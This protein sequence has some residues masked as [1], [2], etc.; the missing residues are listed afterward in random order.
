MADLKPDL[1]RQAVAIIRGFAYQ[2]YQTIRA[3]LQCGPD[4]ELRCEFAEDFDLV[5]RDIAG[6]VMEAEL[7]QVK[8]EKKNVTLNSD[9]VVQLINNFFRH[10][11]I[12]PGLKLKMRLCTISDRSQESRVDWPYATCGMDLWDRL[13]VRELDTKDQRLAIEALRSHLQGNTHLS[14][15]AKNFL[16]N[17]TDSTFLSDFVDAIFWDTG[18]PPYSEIEKE[19]HG[20][21]AV[22]RR[23]ITN[24][25]EV[26]Q[27]VNRLWKAVIDLLASDSDR[28][29]TRA[30]L[31][32]VL[33]KETTVRIDRLLVQEMTAGLGDITQRMDYLVAALT[34]K[35]INSKDAIELRY[36]TILLSDQLPPLHA[37]CSR[38]TQLVDDIR[39][40]SQATS[41]LWICGSTGYG[42]TTIA[43]LI[44]RDV[45]TPFLWFRLRDLVNFE[46]TSAL[47]FILK[48]AN[49]H[50]PC[51]KLLIVLDDLSLG[52]TD[53]RNI[54]LIER[55]VGAAKAKTTEALVIITSQGFSPS[56]L[57]DLVSKQLTAFDMPAMSVDEIRELVTNA[58]LTDQELLPFW[59]TFIQARTHGHPQLV[60]AYI[61]FGKEVG[62]KFSAEDFTNTPQSAESVKSE[63]RRLLAD[64]LHS[65]EARELARRLSVV[66]ISFPR[67]FA[68]AIGRAKPPLKEPGHA[69]DSL[70]GPWIEAIDDKHYSLS[71]L[72]GGYADS[73][74]GPAGLAPFYKMAAYSWFAQKT[75]NQVQF[76]QLVTCALLASEEFLIAHTGY[77]LLTTKEPKFQIM[78]K[79][80]SLICLLG[81]DQTSL[82]DLQPLT[83][84]LFRMGQM[85]I[86]AQIG[87]T[88][89]YMKL[90]AAVLAELEPK[91]DDNIH[92]SFLFSYYLQTS[93]DPNSPVALR[94]R[95]NR[96]IKAVSLFQKR[97][98]DSDYLTSLEVQKSVA[99]VLMLITSK[100]ESMEDLQY[101]VDELGRQSAETITLSLAGFEE[102]PDLL[103]LLADR[104][105]MAETKHQEPRWEQCQMVLSEVLEFAH[106]HNIPWLLAGAARAKMVVFDEYLDKPESALEVANDARQKLGAN[107]PVIDLAESTVRF[108][109]EEYSEC[110]LLFDRADK[111]LPPEH[112]TLERIFALRRVIIAASKDQEWNKIRTCSDRGLELVKSLPDK[113]LAEIATCAFQLEK[114]WASHESGERLSAIE[115]FESA[116]KLAER[117][118]DQRQPLFHLLR[119]RFGHTL[120]WLAYASG[121][122]SLG[123]VDQNASSSRPFSGMFANFDEPPS[124][125][126]DRNGAPYEGLWAMLA[127]YAA[128]YASNTKVKS[129]TDRAVTPT[130]EGQCYLALWS[131][132][133]ALFANQLAEEDFEA[134]LLTGL[135]YVKIETVGSAYSAAGKDAI[136]QGYG[137]FSNEE[138]SLEFQ[139]QWV[140]AIPFRVFEPILM[141]LCSVDN[142]PQINFKAWREVL[143]NRLGTH[144]LIGTTL[145]CL[146]IGL[147][148]AARDAEATKTAHNLARNSPPVIPALQRLGQLI[149]CASKTL[150][151]RECIAAQGSYLLAMPS[152]LEKTLIADTFTRMVAKRWTD[153]AKTQKFLITSPTFYSPIILNATSQKVPTTSECANLL[154]LIAEAVRITWP[155]QM[156]EGLR[157]LSQKAKL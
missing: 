69:F 141:T 151:I 57:S 16:N 28:T 77:V 3:W 55:I 70:L 123:R 86:A 76:L 132:N 154:L 146:E 39:A 51:T 144:D 20:I 75:L 63:S 24:P 5:R 49:Y 153:F 81:H 37:I 117:F 87:Q 40:K 129:F 133:G 95:I 112:V 29:I 91:H 48:R 18:Q 89:T 62:W 109:R 64:S 97:Q 79:E 8:H 73:E 13:R 50:T 142:L 84:H 74:V 103:A 2:C 118:P 30:D 27:V 119:L 26:E 34:S 110:T 58:G 152:P 140:E 35:E 85:R 137:N 130:T 82:K 52:N 19:I 53:T 102:F 147:R 54:E 135:D 136:L 114:A 127:K 45:S 107:H 25:L 44:V 126:L 43:N 92:N 67:D 56:R 155:T 68:L 101:F 128:W 125:A 108:R 115:H 11:S 66:N 10:K 149:C 9:S 21:L 106:Q 41:L 46:L 99:S 65:A 94:E 38:R 116:L 124:T 6:Q 22:R 4:E 105:W 32:S 131:A 42:K 157:L 7:N 47:T 12:N 139:N 88:T 104:V 100:L 80:L 72:L 138:L 78:A 121:Q 71:P 33:S 143:A 17:S 60:G 31:E 113:L 122:G 93:T 96:A 90:D 134:A 14:G 111:D 1:E 120:G 59:T 148:A 83:R 23:P 98:L 145:E 36:E 61:S 156:A 15:E 150:S